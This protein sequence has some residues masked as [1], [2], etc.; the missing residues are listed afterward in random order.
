MIKLV[1][2]P[3]DLPRIRRFPRFGSHFVR[4]AFRGAGGLTQEKGNGSRNP[5]REPAGTARAGRPG[6]LAR[7]R[8]AA[9]EFSAGGSARRPI[10]VPTRTKSGESARKPPLLLAFVVA[11][12]VGAAFAQGKPPASESQFVGGWTVVK[13]VRGGETRAGVDSVAARVRFDQDDG[14]PPAAARWRP[15]RAFWKNRTTGR[16]K[17]ECM[18]G[19]GICSTRTE[20]RC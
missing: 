9:R 20:K 6:N 17:R 4:P 1:A 15:P 12:A 5:S 11:S 8:R 18:G 13:V 16:G 10:D 14:H 7:N 19:I 2:G 3:S